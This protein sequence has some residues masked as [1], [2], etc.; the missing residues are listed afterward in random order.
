MKETKQ[1]TPKT[2]PKM[3]EPL[4]TN[5]VEF[6]LVEPTKN[7]VILRPKTLP[8]KVFF[9]QG[10]QSLPA[11]CKV[12]AKTP[13][14]EP[15]PDGSLGYSLGKKHP[16]LYKS[17][18]IFLDSFGEVSNVEFDVQKVLNTYDFVSERE[19]N[20]SDKPQARILQVKK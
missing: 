10:E 18:I 5:K 9:Y 1:T 4:P 20:E 15:L 2:P 17:A 3:V 11:L 19:V 13:N 12:L 8:K 16:T 7:I 14:L 6:K